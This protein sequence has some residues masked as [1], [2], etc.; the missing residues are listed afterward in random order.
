MN[1]KGEL[2]FIQT[3]IKSVKLNLENDLG[4]F[5][6]CAYGELNEVRVR[7]IEVSGTYNSLVY[8]I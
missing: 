3:K 7:W 4:F 2:G 5:R 8:Y 1:F 6:E